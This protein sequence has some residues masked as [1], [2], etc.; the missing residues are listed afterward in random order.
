MYLDVIRRIYMNTQQ[1][2]IHNTK[3]AGK[4]YCSSSRGPTR[5]VGAEGLLQSRQI[6]L[7]VHC[8]LSHYHNPCINWSPFTRY[9]SHIPKMLIANIFYHIM[10]FS[11]NYCLKSCSERD[12][13]VETVRAKG[14]KLIQISLL[15]YKRYEGKK[16]LLQFGHIHI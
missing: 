15:Q 8:V 16:K 7:V 4:Q 14:S 13:L 11:I 9:T 2:D 1:N 10:N 12:D 5:G 6:R 3:E